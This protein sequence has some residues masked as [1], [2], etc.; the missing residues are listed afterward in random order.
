MGI[1]V[2]GLDGLADDL[3]NHGLEIMAQQVVKIARENGWSTTENIN[4]KQEPGLDVEAIRKRA[5]QILRG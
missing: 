2:T 5:E 1:K 3:N 4:I